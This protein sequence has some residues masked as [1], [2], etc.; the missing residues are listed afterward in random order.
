MAT[1]KAAAK[2]ATPTKKVAAKKEV[3]AA[4]GRTSNFAGK[5]IT[6]V[7]KDNPRREGT[8]G[9]ASF[10]LITSGMTYEKFIEL[11]GRN[12]DLAFDVAKG[13]LKVA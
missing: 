2:K 13:H 3:S 1:K 11:G 12:K 5:K 7:T 10:A 9:H 8:L 6:K 4:S